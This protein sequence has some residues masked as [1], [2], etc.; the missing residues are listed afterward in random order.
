MTSEQQAAYIFAQS[1]CA[2]A[3]IAGMQAENQSRLHRGEAIAYAEQAFLDV[4]NR[5]G[6]S[7]N[8]VISTFHP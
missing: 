6:I 1:V 2:M 8:A 7:H 4:I 5:Y 3:D